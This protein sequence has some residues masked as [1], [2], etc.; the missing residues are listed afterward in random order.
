[1]LAIRGSSPLTRGKLARKRCARKSNRLIP[2]HA[3]KTR[4]EGG[5]CRRRTAHPRSRGENHGR[6]RPGYPAH[7]SSP[8]TRGKRILEARQP[9]I[10]RLI[11][12]HAG[13][14]WRPGRRIRRGSAHPRSRGE[15]LHLVGGRL[16]DRG[17]SP[18]TRGKQVLRHLAT[19]LGRLIPAHAGKTRPRWARLCA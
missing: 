8:L 12:A 1:M 13:K 10:A 15:N 17:S 11:P 4:N 14:T 3:G 7:G 2:A 18:L 9:V 19:E 5:R 6:R 16:K